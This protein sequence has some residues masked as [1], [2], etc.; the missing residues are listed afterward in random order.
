LST[1]LRDIEGALTT[2]DYGGG[3]VLPCVMWVCPECSARGDAH[4]HSHLMPYGPA[5]TRIPHGDGTI[6]VWKHESGSTIDDITLSPSYLVRG[7]SC[8]VHGFVQSG[9][10]VPC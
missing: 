4:S 8:N 10:W 7:Q 3:L 1:A 6:L 9:R 5:L 2:I